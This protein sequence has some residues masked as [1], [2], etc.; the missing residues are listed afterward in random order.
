MVLFV[1]TLLA[2]IP[3]RAGAQTDFDVVGTRA[4]GM[5]GAFVAVADDASAA[6]W[7][8][9][10]LSSIP[11]AEVSVAGGTVSTAGDGS[12]AVS[13]GTRGWRACPISVFFGLPVLGISRYVGMLT[14]SSPTNKKI[15][16]LDAATIIEPALSIKKAPK[17]SG[18]RA[19][20]T[21]S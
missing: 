10:G 15:N 20:S 19:S 18:T 8:P 21:W 4:Q 16:S 11:L 1:L 12:R 3:V 5:G 17:N 6:W 9:A 2:G 7:N 14:S 13:P